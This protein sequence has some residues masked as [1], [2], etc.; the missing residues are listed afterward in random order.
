VRDL[1]GLPALRLRARQDPEDDFPTLRALVEYL[2]KEE[3]RKGSDLKFEPDTPRYAV[4]VIEALDH[5]LVIIGRTGKEALYAMLEERYGLRPA[6]I[7]SKPGQ[8][9]SALQ[10]L[11]GHS[12]LVIEKEMLAWIN[13]T[14]PVRGSSLEDAVD[15]LKAA[16]PSA[17]SRLGP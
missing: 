17:G 16:Y 14:T 7:A 9:V 1:R 3:S 5:A 8:F 13:E 10:H 15:K 12:A 4:V 11:L 2:K 6:D